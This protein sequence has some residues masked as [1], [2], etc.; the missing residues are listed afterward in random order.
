MLSFL[1]KWFGRGGGKGKTAGADPVLDLGP[2]AGAAKMMPRVPRADVHRLMVKATALRR[3]KGYH[4][5]VL[6]LQELAE[7]YLREQNTAL[8]ATLNKLVPYMKKDADLPYAEGKAW[9]ETLIDRLPQNDPYFLNVHITLAELLEQEGV[10]RSIDYLETFLRDHPPSGDT[11]YHLIR[12]ADFYREAGDAGKAQEKLQEARRLWDTSLERYRLI[13]MQRRWHHSAALLALGEEG[14]YGTGE[15]LFHRF[16]EFALDMAR[17]LDPAQPEEFQKRKDQYYRGERGFAGTAAFEK[18]M[19][20]PCLEGRRENLLK[21]VYGFVFEEMP[22]LLGVSEKELH[23][24]PGDPETIEEVRR[25]KLFATLPFTQ[26]DEL[27]SRIRKIG[28]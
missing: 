25:K 19:E 5:A 2:H 15:Y 4:E 8:V 17:V 21:E 6:F 24:R 7:Q 14:E 11:Y 27:E 28:I 20:R 13:K 12:L 9:L 22:Q 18:V 23:F 1:K 16:M 26:Y 10:Q 3:S